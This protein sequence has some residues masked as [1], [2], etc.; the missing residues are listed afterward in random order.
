MVMSLPALPEQSTTEGLKQEFAFSQPCRV[1]VLDQEVRSGYTR[2]SLWLGG[3]RRLVLSS[4]GLP[5]MC[6][7]VLISVSSSYEDASQIGLGPTLRT[8]S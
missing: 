3:G 2:C 7:C 8:S 5:S 1:E 4:R 6:F